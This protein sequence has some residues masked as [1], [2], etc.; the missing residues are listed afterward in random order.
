MNKYIFIGLGFTGA[1][2]VNAQEVVDVYKMTHQEIMGTARYMGMAGAFG[3]L[4]G[5]ISTLSENPAGIGVYRSSEVVATF[6]LGNVSTKAD[7]TDRMNKFNAGF[8]NLGWV[9][10]IKT[11]NT[12]GL[13]SF[14]V[15]FGFN[16]QAGQKR[17]YN[18]YQRDMGYYNNDGDFIRSGV[19]EYIATKANGS[20]TSDMILRN[21]TSNSDYNYNSEI[22]NK[23][24][25]LAILGANQGV[26]SGSGDS[27]TTLPGSEA[28]GN[29][30]AEENYQIDEYTFNV[31]GNFDNII[32]WGVGLGVVDMK[33]KTRT[34]YTERY[35]KS[36]GTAE[37]NDFTLDNYLNT[38][39]SGINVKMGI[40][41]R[42]TNSLRFGV[43]VHTPT[44]YDMSDE[45]G[46]NM[47][48][49]NN[50]V[51]D[52][53]TYTPDGVFDYKLRTPWKYQFSAAY[54]FG[55]AGL[56]SFE[57]E[58]ED[59]SESKLSN[60]DNFYNS[61]FDAQNADIKALLKIQNTYK[62]GLEARLSPICSA[63]LGYAFQSSGYDNVVIDNQ[64]ML[65]ASGT[66]PNYTI[67]KQ[68]QYFTAGL[69]FRGGNFFGDAAFVYKVNK[70][71]AYLFPSVDDWGVISY[72]TELTTNSYRVMLTLG[73]KF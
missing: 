57:Y 26:I 23:Y 15:G 8:N 56:I 1:M 41:A 5:D 55:K 9:G 63:R 32:Y 17:K 73:Y 33:Y 39:G 58:L 36:D 44:W 61:E 3:A 18:I 69:G 21:G 71:D 31:G 29:L 53:A 7:G 35:Y 66:L 52:F 22:F 28:D 48:L 43:A 70:Q 10:T 12:S 30:M 59:F 11:G 47:A 46:A 14:N 40:I 38:K 65:Y 62:V 27:Y 37:P 25:W 20:A 4:G 19:A 72:P 54:V 42:P 49:Y 68:T 2:A 50:N 60:V 45:Y 51:S 64:A 16:R 34:S 6:D 24:S 67:N 13:L